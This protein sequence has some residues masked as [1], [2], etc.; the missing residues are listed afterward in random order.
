MR[1]TWTGRATQAITDLRSFLLR[2][3][4]HPFRVTSRAICNGLHQAVRDCVLIAAAV[5]CSVAPSDAAAG[6]RAWNKCA[7]QAELEAYRTL[8]S[9]HPDNLVID[10]CGEPPV[11]ESDT[12]TGIGVSPYDGP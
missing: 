11:N 7:E 4:S 8:G 6:T 2:A 1:M 5:S 12:A 10:K 3:N 9:E